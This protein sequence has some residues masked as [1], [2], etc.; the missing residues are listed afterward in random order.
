MKC[1]IRALSFYISVFH[2]LTRM[3]RQLEE[4]SWWAG[5]VENTDRTRQLK[6]KMNLN[7]TQKS[8]IRQ[9]RRRDLWVHHTGFT[10]ATNRRLIKENC[11]QEWNCSL[12]FPVWQTLE[13]ILALKEEQ[14]TNSLAAQNLFPLRSEP[15]ARLLFNFLR[16]QVNHACLCNM[17]CKKQAVKLR[18][19]EN[20]QY[21][22]ISTLRPA[23]RPPGNRG[24][25]SS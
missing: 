3:S 24:L 16:Y 13:L 7:K 5:I 21:P 2:L 19:L 22:T 25:P 9:H 23:L 11:T 10:R 20:K 12:C 14:Y 17:I 6:T 18:L 4:K 15:W 8:G 1:S